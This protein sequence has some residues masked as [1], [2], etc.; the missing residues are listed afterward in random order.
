MALQVDD[1]WLADYGCPRQIEE[2]FEVLVSYLRGPTLGVGYGY[3]LPF[4][5]APPACTQPNH[6]SA[7]QEFQFVKEPIA[8]HCV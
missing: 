8:C 7:V 3:K 5:Y 1:F 6:E 4:M 2:M